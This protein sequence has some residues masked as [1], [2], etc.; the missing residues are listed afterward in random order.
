MS[1]MTLLATRRSAPI[2]VLEGPGPDAEQLREILRV[3]SR[4]PDHGKLAPWRFLILED[5]GKARLGEALAAF[6]AEDNPD[7]SEARLAEERARPRRAPVLVV[8]VAKLD[9]QHPKIPEWEQILSGGAACQ[10]LCLAASALGFRAA[11]LTEWPAYDARVRALLGL[12]ETDR[13]LG[14]LYLGST[15]EPVKDRPRP[16]LEDVVSVWA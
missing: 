3:A 6:H 15:R 9:P 13:I 1:A 11:W 4:V 2:G 12:A 8:A 10:N 16:A 14:F 5:A 7:A